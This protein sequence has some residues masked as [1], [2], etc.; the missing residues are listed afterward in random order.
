METLRARGAR[1]LIR[2]NPETGV[3]A[4]LAIASNAVM[5]WK[6]TLCFALSATCVL[7]PL[8][9]NAQT[10]GAPGPTAAELAAA[11]PP[12]RSNRTFGGVSEDHILN[13]I[14][15]ARIVG[16]QQVGSTSVNFHL[17]LSSDTD[18]SFKPRSTS[19]ADAYRAEIA[20]FRLN[21][22]LGLSRVPP[23]ISRYVQRAQLHL[24]TE[25]LV[26]PER[27]G[28]VRGAAIYWVPVLRDSRID[29]ER[30]RTRWS[31]WLRQRDTIPADQ[32]VRAEEISSLVV[33]DFL[34]GNWDRWSGAN[35]PMDAG[36]H[37]IYRDNNGGFGE[38]FG[39]AMLAI[40][41][42][43]LRL[44]QKF[45]RAVIDRARGMTEETVRAEMALDPD[46]AHPPL[47]AVQITSLLR[48]RDTLIAYVDDLV[49]RHSEAA[50]YV[51]P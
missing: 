4:G 21:R 41:M 13:E 26:L 47:S 3:N 46:T 11:A 24:S 40:V 43:Q 15:S 22:L 31:R 37:L 7:G 51:W 35:V 27:D 1:E 44:V 30:E 8:V 17:T 42:R 32:L 2:G 19:H 6:A 39:D 10:P 29:Q 14:H 48:R 12:I 20:A 23:A 16:R 33:F 25:T 45:S 36:G 5:H 28:N 34:I 38:P 49:R 18:A 50:V 9:V